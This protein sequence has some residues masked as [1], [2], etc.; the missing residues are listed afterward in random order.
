MNI[1]S[2]IK[3]IRVMILLSLFFI[4]ITCQLPKGKY[5]YVDKCTPIEVSG[6]T[7]VLEWSAPSTGSPDSYN[8]YFKEHNYGTWELIDSVNSTTFDYIIDYTQL[9]GNNYHDFGIT[10]MYGTEESLLHMSTSDKADPDNGWYVIW[11]QYTESP[12]L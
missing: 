12:E 5:E 10:A 9:D 8:I 2:L 4:I 3:I 7:F 1:R 11:S 6:N